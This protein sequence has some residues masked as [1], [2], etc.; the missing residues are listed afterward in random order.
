MSARRDGQLRLDRLDHGHHAF[1]DVI[2]S[3]L[4]I[5]TT[6]QQVRDGDL[7]RVG[8][9]LDELVPGIT[10]QRC[11][12][13]PRIDNHSEHPQDSGTA[14]L[15]AISRG[16]RQD[17]FAQAARTFVPHVLR[18]LVSGLAAVVEAEMHKMLYLG[19]LRS[20]PPRHLAFSQHHDSNWLAGGG[21]AWDIVRTR[22]DV[23]A[24]VNAWLGDANRLKTPYELVVRNLLTTV[25][26]AA[27][28]HRRLSDGV[29]ARS[30]EEVLEDFE[31]APSWSEEEEQQAIVDALAGA[32]R[33]H[34]DQVEA[35][36]MVDGWIK[37]LLET[38]TESIQDIVLLDKRNGTSVSH[39]DVGIGVS[40]V[41]PVLVSAYASSENLVTIE[42]P[43]IHLHP[44]LQAE[45]GD[46]FLESALGAGGNTFLLETHSEHLI[47]R[48][49]RRIRETTEGR[50]PEGCP[51]VRPEQ[52]AV[53]YVQPGSDGAEVV[54]IPVTPDGEFERPWP[55]G[56][57]AERAKELY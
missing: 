46:V 34:K 57:F 30:D 3:I 41:L 13:F 22:E 49:L 6:A 7:E 8:E 23:R 10:G 16:R 48:I 27:D 37:E 53:L 18:D 51:A 32:D 44:A 45:L 19:P 33:E 5:G 54:H 43:E 21:H 2:R 42:Q 55:D 14:S 24:R 12:L 39:R 11:G 38:R 20:Y 35:V 50:L 47:L 25:A 28:L 15:L 36:D 9:V 56:F 17:D 29:Q 31:F 40:Q 1:R 4:T 26:F 52:V